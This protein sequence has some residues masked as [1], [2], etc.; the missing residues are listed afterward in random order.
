MCERMIRVVATYVCLFRGRG[1]RLALL[2]KKH[3]RRK[4]ESDKKGGKKDT[5]R[6]ELNAGQG[7]KASHGNRHLLIYNTGR[8]TWR[9]FLESE[10][11]RRCGYGHVFGSESELEQAFGQGKG[12]D[13]RYA[14]VFFLLILI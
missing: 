7:K 5:K 4:S 8:G 13:S 14:Q 3:T 6:R 2:I 1:T 10:F 9:Y 11:A 12:S